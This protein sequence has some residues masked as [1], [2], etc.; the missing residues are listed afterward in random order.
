MSEKTT[1]PMSLQQVRSLSSALQHIFISE[2]SFILRN[3]L[4]FTSFSFTSVALKNAV[5]HKMFAKLKNDAEKEKSFA[6]CK[7]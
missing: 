6:K 7:L 3:T 1:V 2:F 5:Y 4:M